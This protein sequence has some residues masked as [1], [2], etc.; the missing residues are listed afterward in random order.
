VE[1]ES[2]NNIKKRLQIQEDDGDSAIQETKK[3]IDQLLTEIRQTTKSNIRKA[4]RQ[5]KK[6]Y[7]NF[8]TQICKTA[9]DDGLGNVLDTIQVYSPIIFE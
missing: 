1:E 4:Q 7:I 3:P 5:L 2:N 6:I 9:F 8:F